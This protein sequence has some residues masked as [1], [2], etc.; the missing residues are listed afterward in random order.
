MFL[1]FILIWLVIFL[2]PIAVYALSVSFL[3][4]KEPDRKSR[5]FLSVVIQKVGTTF[6]FLAIFLLARE[7]I[8]DQWLVYAM[9]W[10]GMFSITEMGQALMPNYSKREALAGIISELIYFPLA[11]FI[12]YSLL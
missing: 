3:G 5:F 12:A 8:G 11:A 9:V 10:F 1:S 2:V 6:G 7:A 4:L